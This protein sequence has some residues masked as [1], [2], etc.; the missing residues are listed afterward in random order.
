MLLKL[1]KVP[2]AIDFFILPLEGYDVVLGTQWLR[3][4]GP[5]QWDFEKL[6][7][8]FLKDGKEIVLHGVTCSRI[9][10][11]PDQ[12]LTQISKSQ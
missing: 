12:S 11:T 4:L 8:K 5:I 7:M 2:F 6:L 9:K 10:V 3:T 1:Q